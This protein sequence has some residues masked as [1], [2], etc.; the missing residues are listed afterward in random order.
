MKKEFSLL[1]DLC[2]AGRGLPCTRAGEPVNLDSI[3]ETLL[4]NIAREHKTAAA[5]LT[6]LKK[7]GRALSSASM[8]T[9][10]RGVT[11]GR[12]AR[13]FLMEEW[14]RIE[15]TLFRNGIPMIT[16]K[17]P[18]SSTQL[19]GNPVTREYSDLDIIV[20]DVPGLARTVPV[21]ESLGYQAQPPISSR[22][23]K[24]QAWYISEP[25]HLTFVNPS[26]P[27]RVEVHS[28]FFPEAGPGS[29]YHLD[30]IF[31]RA[32]R[33][34]HA[35]KGH[36]VPSL[37]DHALYM[38]G[39][40]TK[41]AW[42]QL[43]WV[44]DAA[45]LLSRNTCDFH[46]GLV[47]GVIALGM[48]KQL[49]LLI[50][51]VQD[52]FPIPVPAVYSGITGQYARTVTRQLRIAQDRLFSRNTEHQ[53]IYHILY[54]SWRYQMSFVTGIRG[55]TAVLLQPFLVTRTDADALPLPGLLRPLHI[56]LRPFFVI[57]RRIGRLAKGWEGR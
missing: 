45:A 37:I 28:T 56:L 26:S 16:I 50:A 29:G 30:T 49:T 10:T 22:T 19:Y 44:L 20:R 39:H 32:E 23:P 57:S 51:L 27:F 14:D 4:I 25:H 47:D 8:N 53:P 21:M 24:K 6:G 5:M 18:A 42:S 31:Q 2:A 7:T 13:T 55:K 48:E 40:G 35:G 36:T 11:R 46:T 17:G 43:H 41:H 34:E 3:D 52:L 15:Q 9:L 1:I 12:A 38:I 54:F 33:V